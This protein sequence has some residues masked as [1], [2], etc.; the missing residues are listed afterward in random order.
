MRF[1]IPYLCVVSQTE[2]INAGSN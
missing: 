2:A 1:K